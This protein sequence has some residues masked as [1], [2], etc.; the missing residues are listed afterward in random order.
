[1]AHRIVIADDTEVMRAMIRLALESAGFEVVAEATSGAEVVEMYRE[2]RPDAVTLDLRMGDMDGLDA[3]REILKFDP[4]LRF[5]V[6]TSRGQEEHIRAAVEIGAS[7]FVIK[8]FEPERIIQA[9]ELAV[10]K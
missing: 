4:D 8:P 9:M 2:F 10:A 7:D 6:C 3:A 1:M 5:I